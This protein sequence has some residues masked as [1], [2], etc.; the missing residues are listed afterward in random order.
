MKSG[1][2]KLNEW[3]RKMKELCEPA[4]V[5]MC[6]GTQE[7]YDALCQKMVESGTFLK[8]K[9][10]GSYY[11]RSNPED[12][13]RVEESTYICSEKKRTPAP[14]TIG[15]IPMRWRRSSWPYLKGACAAGRST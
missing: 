4:N 6:D 3:I 12:V 15:R 13:A 1:N 11:A 8:L 2:Q 5:H 10:P 14:P 9:R 7:E